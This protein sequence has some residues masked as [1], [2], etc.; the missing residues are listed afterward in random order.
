[1]GRGGA[2]SHK[3]P[4]NFYLQFLMSFVGSKKGEEKAHHILQ[5]KI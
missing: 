4:E 5:S 1:M 3:L 2:T